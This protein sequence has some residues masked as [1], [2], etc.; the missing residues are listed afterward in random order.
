M[1]DSGNTFE[2]IGEIA[3]GEVL[4]DD[5]LDLVTVLGVRLLQQVG[6]ART[7]DPYDT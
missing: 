7:R 4:D 6:L 1:N 3:L 5:D 2:R